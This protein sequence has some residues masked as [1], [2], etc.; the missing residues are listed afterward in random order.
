MS[1][2][3]VSIHPSAQIGQNVIIEPFSVIGE[4]VVIGDHCVI[5]PNASIL[6]GARIGNYC[7][8]F[9]GAVIAAEPQ[10]LKYNGE[11]TTVTV[12]DFTTIRECVT[13]N[14]GTALDRGNTGIGERC[15]IMAYTHVAHDCV[16][17]NDVILANSVQM[18]G[19]VVI[20]EFAF[21][22]GT[23]AIH[24]YVKIGSHTMISGGSLVRKDVPPFITAA[25]EPL[26]YLGI[27]SVGLRRRGFTDAKINELQEIYRLF[28]LSGMHNTEALDHIRTDLVPSPE[29]DEI[30][31][32]IE[33]SSRGLI[34]SIKEA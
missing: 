26:T 21:I 5:G 30:I 12:G 24:Q 2:S 23:T 14:K 33:R 27:N 4:G 7:K 31:Q 11:D 32:F 25:R 10:D 17:A 22:G 20:E 34:R 29:R 3:L 9:P 16:I 6:K 28:Y 15:T 13:I 8:V 19:H 18:A 1:N